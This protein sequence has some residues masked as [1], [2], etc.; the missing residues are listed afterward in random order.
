MGVEMQR[1]EHQKNCLRRLSPAMLALAFSAFLAAA[2]MGHCQGLTKGADLSFGAIVPYS[3]G[4]VKVTPLG[5]RSATGGVL[6]VPASAVSAATFTVT[7]A[8]NATYAI[9]L[10]PPIGTVTLSDGAGHSMAVDT[11]TSDPIGSGT[12]SAA[13]P[14]TQELKVGATLHVAASQAVG[15]Y[16]GSYEVTVTFN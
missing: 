11:F 12:V 9:S 13:S 4:T 1:D 5:V 14:G 16:T 3:G 7:G 15:Q 6:P 10:A 8:S 2:Q